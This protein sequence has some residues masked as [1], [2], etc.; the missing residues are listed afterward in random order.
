MGHLDSHCHFDAPAFAPDRLEVASRAR[1]QGLTDL[2]VPGVEVSNF[3]GEPLSVPGLRLWYAAGLHPVFD[4][5]ADGLERLE[6]ALQTGRFVALGETGLDKRCLRPGSEALCAA[7]LDLALAFKLPVILHVVHAHEAVLAL[8]KERPGLRGVVHAFSGSREVAKRYLSLGFKLGLGGIGTWGT[9]QKLH[10]AI[11]AC[12]ADGYTLET[13]APDLS[14]E[15]WR[16]RR[17]EPAA[18]V[19]VAEAVAKLRGETATEV[20]ACSDANGRALF[21]IDINRKEES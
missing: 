11:A 1:E 6:A 16:G 3:E 18:L 9:A 12:P 14:P 4:H 10:K 17:N 2:V 21:G 5:P 19:D 20:L 15:T 8:L 13:D 7:Q